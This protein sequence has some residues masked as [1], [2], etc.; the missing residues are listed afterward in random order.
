[1]KKESNGQTGTM[2][3]ITVEHNIIFYINRLR[4]GSLTAPPIPNI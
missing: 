1:M 3:G 2:L 4:L